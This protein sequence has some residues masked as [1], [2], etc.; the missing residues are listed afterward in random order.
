MH[1]DF[2]GVELTSIKFLVATWCLKFEFV[3]RQNLHFQL[4]RQ[5]DE[6]PG[7]R[8][9]ENS[10]HFLIKPLGVPGFPHYRCQDVFTLLQESGPERGLVVP[11]IGCMALALPHVIEYYLAVEVV[12][13]VVVC[14]SIQA[15][16]ASPVGRDIIDCENVAEVGV[17]VALPDG[18]IVH[19]AHV[20]IPEGRRVKG[21]VVI[22]VKIQFGPAGVAFITRVVRL[23]VVGTLVE[24]CTTAVGVGPPPFGIVVAA[25]QY[26]DIPDFTVVLGPST[27]GHGVIAGQG[28]RIR[29]YVKGY[30]TA[31]ARLE[32]NHVRGDGYVPAIV[33]S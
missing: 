1:P 10:L 11:V 14:S 25:T 31:L 20:A 32:M 23:I 17:A 22:I 16:A 8:T 3:A 7:G 28:L 4:Q 29:D 24:L 21:P 12:G 26:H 33:G 27:Q 5:R 15:Q 2:P 9:G 19:V 18:V 30:V 13:T 6:I